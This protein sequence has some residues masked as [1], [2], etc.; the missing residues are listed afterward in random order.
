MSAKPMSVEELARFKTSAKVI[1]D[2]YEGE[3]VALARA[4]LCVVS[5]IE[6]RDE[7][8]RQLRNAIFDAAGAL[9]DLRADQTVDYGARK[10]LEPVIEALEAAVGGVE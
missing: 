3:V 6:A 5:T 10:R 7:E 2:V 9:G 4:S 8:I 1:V